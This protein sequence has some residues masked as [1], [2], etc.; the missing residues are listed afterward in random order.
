MLQQDFKIC[1][2]SFFINDA[3]WVLDLIPDAKCKALD[4]NTSRTFRNEFGSTSA[5]A[6]ISNLQSKDEV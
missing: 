3:F 6:L 1:Q 2:C 4:V 5:L